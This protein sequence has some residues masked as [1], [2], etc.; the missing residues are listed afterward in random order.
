MCFYVDYVMMDLEEGMLCSRR[1][2]PHGTLRL[3]LV[4]LLNFLLIFLDD[5]MTFDFHGG[6]ELSAS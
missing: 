5:K 4:H 3:V 1:S 2:S 6:S